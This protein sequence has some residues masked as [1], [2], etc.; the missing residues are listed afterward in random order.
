MRVCSAPCFGPR[1]FS[2]RPSSADGPGCGCP[3]ATDRPVACGRR[4]PHRFRPGGLRAPLLAVR[5][6]AGHPAPT[7]MRP[8]TRGLFARELPHPPPPPLRSSAPAFSVLP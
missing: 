4:V 6:Q 5:H 2:A 7:S 8:P 1:T 3:C